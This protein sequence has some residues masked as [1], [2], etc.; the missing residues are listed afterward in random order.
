MKEQLAEIAGKSGFCLFGV[1]DPGE[2]E[3]LPPVKANFGREI[4]FPNPRE[5]MVSCNSVIVVGLETRER[6]WDTVVTRENIRAQFYR[7]SISSRLHSLSSFIINQGYH[8]LATE[9]ISI[10]RAATLAG[11]GHA[12]KNTLIAHPAYGS[13]LRW[14]A[15]LTDALILPD[16]PL[17]SESFCGDCR[18]CIE[19][20][21][22]GAIEEYRID[23]GKCLVPALDL[24]EN[25]SPEWKLARKHMPEADGAHVEC[26]ICQKV[27][28]YGK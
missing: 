12:G 26:S 1:A 19:A 17:E 9:A 25:D 22:A 15:L 2:F 5:V 24:A 21:P 3:E 4:V 18:R 20:C 11:L 28:C 7:E 27:C 6:V 10:K 14:G 23:F 8:A 13:N 16:S